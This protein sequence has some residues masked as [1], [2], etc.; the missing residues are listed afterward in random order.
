M[1][2]KV[3]AGRGPGDT[4]RFE[5][6]RR[7]SAVSE[8][9][10]HQETSQEINMVVRSCPG[11]V[12]VAVATVHAVQPELMQAVNTSGIRISLWGKS[13]TFF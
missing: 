8:A 11:G 5:Q 4:T 13:I 7:E 12:A 2:S 9:E 6:R 3:A 10:E 1:A